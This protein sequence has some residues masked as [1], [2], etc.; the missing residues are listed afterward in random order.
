[1]CSITLFAGLTKSARMHKHANEMR[2]GAGHADA[3]SLLHALKHA[4]APKRALPALRHVSPAPQWRWRQH[5][6]PKDTNTLDKEEKARAQSEVPCCC[7]QG[8]QHAS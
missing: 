1:L 4:A 5:T 3:C 7:V 2:A 6:E 8:E